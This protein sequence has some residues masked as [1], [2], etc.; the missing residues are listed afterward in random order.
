[1]MGQTTMSLM[2][3]NVKMPVM[4]CRPAS[5]LRPATRI[6]PGVSQHPKLQYFIAE[7]PKL[8]GDINTVLG[9]LA[10][11]STSIA[12]SV[13]VRRDDGEVVEL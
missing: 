13:G 2:P 4:T 11:Q 9:L 5:F 1:M 10:A 7:E 8:K 12:S 6:S 3:H